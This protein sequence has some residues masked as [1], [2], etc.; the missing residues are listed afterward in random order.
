MDDKNTDREANTDD[1][2]E[3]EGWE[4]KSHTLREASEG[5]KKYE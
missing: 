3:A 4:I 1:D 2:K 5:K